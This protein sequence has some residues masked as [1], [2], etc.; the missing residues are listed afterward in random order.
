MA[1]S[2]YPYPPDQFDE[3]AARSAYHGAHRAE[4]SFWRQNLVYL[5]IIGVAL[6]LLLG[7]LF[8]I[9]G[10]GG[11]DDQ[12]AADPTT[13]AAQP[14]DAGGASDG[15]AAASPAASPAA[16]A[17]Q[18][19]AVTVINAAGI[20]GMAGAWRSE[21]QGAG[22]TSVSIETS[23]ARQQESVVF[24][25]DEADAAT[26]QAL[27]DHVGAGQAR[28]SDEYSAPVTFVAVTEPQG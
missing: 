25:R 2:S 22:W 8:A 19:T 13:S 3:E 23:D 16:V 7:L 4:E 20:N 12:R 5:V 10:L 6:L 11:K 17:D 15:S 9:G 18:S 28:Q 14:S 27:A 26:A 21:L 24:Y 1:D